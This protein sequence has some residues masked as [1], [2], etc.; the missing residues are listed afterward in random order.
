MY[1]PVPAGKRRK[2]TKHGSSTQG[3]MSQDFSSE[4]SSFPEVGIID[5]ELE[6]NIEYFLKRLIDHC[7]TTHNILHILKINMNDSYPTLEHL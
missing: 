1:R 4:I 6:T 2:S 5:V 7:P 3:W